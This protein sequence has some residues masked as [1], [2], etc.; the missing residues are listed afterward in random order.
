MDQEGTEW[1]RVQKLANF[2]DLHRHDDTTASADDKSC[3][4]ATA[5]IASGSSGYVS[6]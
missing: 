6:F 3:H 1:L 2:V 5:A 4:F